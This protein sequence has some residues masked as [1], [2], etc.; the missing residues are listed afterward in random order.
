VRYRSKFLFIWSLLFSLAL[1]GASLETLTEYGFQ[2]L[3]AVAEFVLPGVVGLG[4]FVILLV[5]FRSFL[6]LSST[7]DIL[8]NFKTKESSSARRFTRCYR[9]HKSLERHTGSVCQNCKWIRCECGAYRC[10]RGAMV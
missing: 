10:G 5:Y 4:F 3:N 6:P 2:D 9:C 7:R 1:L 8:K